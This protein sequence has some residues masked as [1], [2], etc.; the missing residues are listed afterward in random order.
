MYSRHLSEKR[1]SR[2]AEELHQVAATRTERRQYDQVDCPRISE[3]A[4]RAAAC[5]PGADALR[6]WE[7]AQLVRQTETRGR[8]TLNR[9]E[10]AT[11]V[12]RAAC[13]GLAG[14]TRSFIVGGSQVRDP[15][16]QPS[17]ASSVPNPLLVPARASRKP[18]RADP[19]SKLPRDRYLRGLPAGTLALLAGWRRRSANVAL[20]LFPQSAH[21]T[22]PRFRRCRRRQIRLRDYRLWK[23]GNQAR[24]PAPSRQPSVLRESK[25]SPRR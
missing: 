11:L 3:S 6:D 10:P 1:P 13:R 18:S 24:S 12:Y 20:H 4:H 5:P 7:R 23:S 8:Q 2:A 14:R 21:A 15:T 17:S 16:L 9:R 22:N 19:S 25:C